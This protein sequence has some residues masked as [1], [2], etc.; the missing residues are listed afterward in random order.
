MGVVG[1]GGALDMGSAPLE[2]SSGSAPGKRSVANTVTIHCGMISETQNHISIT[3][4]EDNLHTR[5]PLTTRNSNC[6]LL[7]F[8][9]Q[10]R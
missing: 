3:Q 10:H 9:S 8:S 1:R 6:A 2:T 5:R 7:A 4:N